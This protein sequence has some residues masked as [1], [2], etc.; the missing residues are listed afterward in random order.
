MPKKKIKKM[1][2][3]NAL[4]KRGVLGG[5]RWK[6]DYDYLKNL[7]PKE[8]DWLESFTQEEYGNNF[9]HA[10]KKLNKTKKDKKRIFNNTN[11][12]NRCIES[13]DRI[14]TTKMLTKSSVET[15]LDNIQEIRDNEDD[16]IALLDLKKI[17]RRKNT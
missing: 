10:G 3:R 11:A 12:A 16:L 2:P 6:I 15:Y 4:A 17:K 14:N 7:S 9:N 8:L 1:K 5:R 13:L